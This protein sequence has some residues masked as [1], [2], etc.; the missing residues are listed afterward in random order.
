MGGL[1]IAMD[2]VELRSGFR[3]LVAS[4]CTRHGR[5]LP[6]AWKVVEGAKFDL[7][8]NA[9]EDEFVQGLAKM[10]DPARTCIVAD[11]GFRRVSFLALLDSLGFGYA[12]P[13]LRAR[14]RLRDELHRASRRVRAQGGAGGRPRPRRVPGGRGHHHADSDEVGARRRRTVDHSDEHDAEEPP[15][16]M[17]DIRPA[18]GGRRRSLPRRSGFDGRKR[19]SGTSRVI[20]SGSRSRRRRRRGGPAS[21]GGIWT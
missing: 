11:R 21:P 19:A 1:V 6:I 4:A 16:D 18:H 9:V 2:W 20:A 13:S 14:P 7:S 12:I 10:V 5:A 3:G 17:R 15:Q 8:Q